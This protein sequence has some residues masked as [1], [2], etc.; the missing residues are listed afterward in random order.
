MKREVVK[1]TRLQGDGMSE[2]HWEVVDSVAG[3]IQAELLRGLL[4]SQGIPAYL[5]QEGIGHF[6]YVVNVGALGKVDILVPSSTVEAALAVLDAYYAGEFAVQDK[7]K[8][9]STEEGDSYS[10]MGEDPEDEPDTE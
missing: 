7:G 4:I 2:Q 8:D 6:G 3:E 1:I 5:S 10:E 9:E